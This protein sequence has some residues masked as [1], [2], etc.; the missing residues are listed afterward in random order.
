MIRLLAFFFALCAVIALVVAAADAMVDRRHDS[1]P[2]VRAIVKRADVRIDRPFPRDG[3]GVV[4][5]LSLS[6]TTNSG[7]SREIR[8]SSVRK[9]RV[10]DEWIARHGVGSPVDVRLDPADARYAELVDPEALPLPRHWRKDLILAAIAAG[11]S[12]ALFG[13]GAIRSRPAQ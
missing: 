9:S 1:W 3:G 2:V 4:Y 11:L 13:I 7:E 12:I 5:Q 6:V 8:T 10:L